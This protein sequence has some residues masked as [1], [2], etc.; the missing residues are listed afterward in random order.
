LAEEIISLFPD[1]V[2]AAEGKKERSYIVIKHGILQVPHIKF[3]KC[4]TRSKRKCV[5]E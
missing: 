2:K 5:K 3:I 1:P 4:I